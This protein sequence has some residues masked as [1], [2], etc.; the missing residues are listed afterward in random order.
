MSILFS[1]AI[2]E[3]YGT[4]QTFVFIVCRVT[5]FIIATP[6]I[7]TR[8]VNA[9]VKTA[10]VLTIS[11][12]IFANQ[13]MVYLENILSIETILIVFCQLLIGIAMGMIVTLVFQVFV[14]AGELVA[15][16]S[17]LGMAVMNDPASNSSVP[18]VSQFFLIM[19]T[20][21]FFYLDGHLKFIQTLHISFEIIPVGIDCL[22]AI[23]FKQVAMFANWVYGNAFRIAVPMVTGLLMVQV[24][25]GVMT[26]SAPQLNIFSIGFPVTMVLG[27]IILYFNVHIIFPHFISSFEYSQDFIRSEILGVGQ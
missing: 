14:I 4:L 25:L 7:G 15:M 5:G 26:K 6:M 18:V 27:V 22:E 16:Q 8:I 10:L 17:G 23:Q 11:A 2:T 19:I 21:L 1:F 3:L 9:R 20:V 12:L 24:G 13:K